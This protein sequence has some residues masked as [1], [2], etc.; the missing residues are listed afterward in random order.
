MCQPDFARAWP[1]AATHHP[2]V[3]NC[4]V[5]RAERALLQEMGIFWQ[6]IGDGIILR[7]FQDFFER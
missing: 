6:L 4:M 5:W 2:G 3:R 1:V 7:N